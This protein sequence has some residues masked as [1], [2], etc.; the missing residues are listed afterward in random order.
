MPGPF[1]HL[2]EHARRHAERHQ[3]LLF[4]IIFDTSGWFRHCHVPVVLAQSAEALRHLFV[5]GDFVEGHPAPRQAHDVE[6]RRPL[7]Q[8][9]ARILGI[10]RLPVVCG[11]DELSEGS[12]PFFRHRN[13]L[14][15]HTGHGHGCMHPSTRSGSSRI[16]IDG[17]FR[18]ANARFRTC[19]AREMASTWLDPHV[20]N[21]RA[22]NFP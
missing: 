21:L 10:E 14:Q 20:T 1:F 19:F 12:E 6:P 8:V 15:A 17:P 13:G 9:Q 2:Q 16:A 18:A 3:I 22:V 4:G 7:A 5:V 11:T